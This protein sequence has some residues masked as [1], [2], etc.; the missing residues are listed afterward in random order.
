[1][2]PKVEIDDHKDLITGLI[3]QKCKQEDIRS[4]LRDTHSINIGRTAFQSRLREWG[5]QNKLAKANKAAAIQARVLELL[6]V[7]NPKETLAVLAKD[8]YPTSNRT[9]QRIRKRLGVRLRVKKLPIERAEQ[10]PDI[11]DEDQAYQAQ[12]DAQIDAQIAAEAAQRDIESSSPNAAKG[13]R[14]ATHTTSPVVSSPSLPVTT[15][16]SM[17]EPTIRAQGERGARS[18][19]SKQAHMPVL[20][21]ARRTQRKRIL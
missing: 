17:M 4:L 20:R 10:A 14:I 16:S 2:P 12:I 7:C 15:T 5:L 9:L 8:G 11:I 21:P 18:R 1:M 19:V 6:P 13:V 3:Q